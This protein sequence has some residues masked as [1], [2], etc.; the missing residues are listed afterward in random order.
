MVLLRLNNNSI[1][2][3]LEFVFDGIELEPVIRIPD[4]ATREYICW[5]HRSVT[6]DEE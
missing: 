1:L 6:I 5:L 4:A 3:E 2:R